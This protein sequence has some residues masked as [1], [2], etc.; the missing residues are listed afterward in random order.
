[1]SS[2]LLLLLALGGASTVLAGPTVITANGTF[3]GAKCATTDVNLFLSIPYAKAPVGDLRFAPPQPI[4]T[5]F[6]IR[7]ATQAAPAC[8]QFNAEF[9]ETTPTSEDW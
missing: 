1:M 9:A 2:R 5:A 4:D 8:K 6:G 7:D 3:Q